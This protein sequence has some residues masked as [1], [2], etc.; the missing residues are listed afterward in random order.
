MHG[1]KIYRHLN[2]AVKEENKAQERE[3][4]VSL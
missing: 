3:H 4:K 1:C 2:A